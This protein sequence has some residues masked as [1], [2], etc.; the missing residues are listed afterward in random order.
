M[1]KLM[2]FATSLVMF[3]LFMISCNKQEQD[4][5]FQPQNIKSNNDEGEDFSNIEQIEKET[6]KVFFKK[7]VTIKDESGKN[8]IV[9]RFAAA[10]RETLEGYLSTNA[11]SIKP[12]GKLGNSEAPRPLVKK[13]STEN[14]KPV[15]SNEISIFT[16]MIS[17]KLATDI[18]GLIINV[19]KNERE[20]KNARPNYNYTATHLSSA[21]PE[22]LHV[23]SFNNDVQYDIR[24]KD[25]N[26]CGWYIPSGGGG[27]IHYPWEGEKLWGIDGP[28]YVN[29]VIDFYDYTDYSFWYE[30]W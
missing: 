22:L 26:W 1:K 30:N 7:D 25:C 5:P 23:T 4:L 27:I 8:E 19:K 20:L 13:T 14:T 11:Y 16:E 6:G 18:R 28:K 12:I 10:D 2:Y 17:Q 21:W 29:L 9:I 24:Y 3:S 15:V